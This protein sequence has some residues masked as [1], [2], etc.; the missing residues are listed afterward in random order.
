MDI[1]YYQDVLDY[2]IQ[3][4][5]LLIKENLI[6]KIISLNLLEQGVQLD[7]PRYEKIVNI[8][9]DDFLA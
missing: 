6:N 3:Y 7:K 8:C 2:I 4:D 5:T 1:S 9:I